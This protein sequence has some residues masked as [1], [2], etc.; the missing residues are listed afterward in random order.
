[1]EFWDEKYR[2]YQIGCIQD[3]HGALNLELDMLIQFFIQ[4]KE[5]KKLLYSSF[6]KKKYSHDNINFSYISFSL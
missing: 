2:P 4:K 1:M 3:R 6:Q 5:R